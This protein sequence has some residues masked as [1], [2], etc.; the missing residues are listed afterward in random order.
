MAK[1]RTIRT[2]ATCDDNFTVEV[3]AGKHT[4]YVDQPEIAG[5]NDVGPSPLE[6]FQAALAGCLAT[7][8]RIV[9]TQQNIPLHGLE[10]A[11][12][13][14]FDAGRLLGKGKENRAGFTELR[15]RLEIDAALTVQEKADF[16]EAVRKRCPMTDNICQTTPLSLAVGSPG[17]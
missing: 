12:E 7:T 14:D 16:A 11:V 17:L 9:A 13:G 2:T 4:F 10:I 1:L 3:K 6:Y 8:A 15:V 5:G